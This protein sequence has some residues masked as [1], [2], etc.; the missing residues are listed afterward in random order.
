MQQA[1]PLIYEIGASNV[2]ETGNIFYVYNLASEASLP[3]KMLWPAL[4]HCIHFNVQQGS[5]HAQKIQHLAPLTKNA[6]IGERSEPM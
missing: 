1:H 2:W 4:L 3:N 5:N 6:I